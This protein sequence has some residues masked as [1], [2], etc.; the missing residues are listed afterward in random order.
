MPCF[1]QLAVLHQPKQEKVRG[2]PAGRA[3]QQKEDGRGNVP[4]Q[5]GKEGAGKEGRKKRLTAGAHERM[6]ADIACPAVKNDSEEQGGTEEG[7]AR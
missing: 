6:P 5:H 2:Y 1:F 3:G 4:V 7:Q